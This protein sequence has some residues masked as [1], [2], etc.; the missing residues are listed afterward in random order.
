M[1]R[2]LQAETTARIVA[3]M[4][5]AAGPLTARPAAACTGLRLVAADGGV[6][7]GRTME[8]GFDVAS[9]AIV[10][11]ANTALADT[12]PEEGVGLRYTARHGFVGANV[13]G[14]HAIVDGLNERGL[15]VGGFYFP[16]YASYRQMTDEVADRALA[17]EDYGAW[18]LATCSDVAEVK[19]RY[20]EVVLVPK[21][22][23]E[24]GGQSFPGHWVVHDPSGA[25]VV[26][27]PV[28]GGLTI[29]ANPLGVITNSPTFD[30]HLTNLRNY[31][32]LTA[33]NVPQ[34]Q[35]EGR[36]LAPFGQGTGLLGLPGDFTPPSRFVRAVVYS[37][38]ATQLA[39][40]EETTLQAFH[41]MNAFD[42][43]VGAVRDVH[44]DG[45]H[46]DYTVWTS[47][48]DLKNLRWMFR[49]YGDQSIRSIDVRDA[50]SAA[51]PTI[52]RIEMD[53]EQPITDVS[54][55]FE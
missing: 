43:P 6:V 12:L 48:A 54:T 52:R 18:L 4:L 3:A 19:R 38:S 2:S 13:L 53:S 33:T 46:N 41:L 25:S 47:V 27:E 32:N 45:D 24:I 31:L 11:P 37:Q 42:I 44:P 17:P 30:W 55:R 20:N 9:D 34:L 51:G 1:T 15:Y 40:A 22:T 29:H 10:V 28:N 23:P 8:F 7:V 39:T 36:T 49:T 35:L 5:V 14:K 21:P 16:G 50:L 26:I